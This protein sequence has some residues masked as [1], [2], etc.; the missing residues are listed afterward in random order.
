MKFISAGHCNYPGKNYDPGAI[1]YGG[2]K[3]ADM[4]VK[5]RDKTLAYLE[6][7]GYNDFKS[8]LN[9]ES[10]S[11]YLKRIQPGNASVVCEFHLDAATS[12]NATGCT[13][14]IGEDANKL[15]KDAATEIAITTSQILG[16]KN[17]GVISERDS[18]R[19][20]LGLMREDGIVFLVEVCFITNKN[21]LESLDKH[22]EEL[23]SKYA[24]L[25]IK[26]DDLV[27]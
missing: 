20:R 26:Y 9:D 23:C 14:L 16:I 1:G 3:E 19:G 11:L 2:R 10:L 21:D 6:Q 27:K 8:D 12:P 22:I 4:T 24:D 15:D 13:V 18:H 25:I 5:I 7:K 17:R